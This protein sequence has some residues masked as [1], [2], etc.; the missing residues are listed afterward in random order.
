MKAI[1]Q[2]LGEN[3]PTRLSTQ[4]NPPYFTPF[5]Q[6]IIHTRLS[7]RIMMPFNIT[8]AVQHKP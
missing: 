6:P 2:S 1:F 3:I 5:I 4:H 8:R 7:F